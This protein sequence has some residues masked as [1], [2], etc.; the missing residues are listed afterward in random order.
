MCQDVVWIEVTTLVIPD[1][2]DSEKD[3]TEIV[4]YISSLDPSIPCHVSQFYPTYLLRDKPR[5]PIEKLKKA[6][7]IGYGKGL[8]YVYEGNVPGEGNENTYCFTCKE[9]VVKRYGYK[10]LENRIRGSSCP[11]CGS[12]VDGLWTA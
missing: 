5:T 11:E 6:L 2:N 9:M 1:L 8:K 7:E 10:I 4:E 3:L 12:P